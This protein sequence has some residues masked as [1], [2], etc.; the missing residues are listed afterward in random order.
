MTLAAVESI[1]GGLFASEITKTPGAST[2][3]KGSLVTYS[4]EIKEKLGV[5][6]SA[7]VVNSKVALAMAQKGQAFF[8]VDLCVAFTGNA[9]P[10]TLDQ[11]PVGKVFIAINEQVYELDFKGDRQSIREQSVAFALKK[12][13]K[14]LPKKAI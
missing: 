2:F 8:Q 12:I 3:F 13:S 9:G 14:L 7:G 6:I 10:T 11:K 5:D 1:T 4:N